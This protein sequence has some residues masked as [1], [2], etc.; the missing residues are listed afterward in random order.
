MGG[1]EEYIEILYP[2]CGKVFAQDVDTIFVE[3][4]LL[5]R[6]P[7]LE[8]WITDDL[9]NH[10]KIEVNESGEFAAPLALKYGRNVIRIEGFKPDKSQRTISGQFTFFNITIFVMKEVKKWP[11]HI[12]IDEIRSRY[13]KNVQQDE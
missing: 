6:H 3:G 12:H 1:G 10:S 4:R 13:Q 2:P 9:G 11:R 7:G 8:V 5:K